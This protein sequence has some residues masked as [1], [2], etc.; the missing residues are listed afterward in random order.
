M[1]RPAKSKTKTKTLDKS[2]SINEGSNK[3]GGLEFSAVK[4]SGNADHIQNKG[5]KRK[6]DFAEELRGSEFGPSM[7]G[8]VH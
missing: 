4:A 6:M 1:S 2:S 8:Y 5:E 3:P 7:I